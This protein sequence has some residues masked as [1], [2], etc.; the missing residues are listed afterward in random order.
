MKGLEMMAASIMQSM[1]VDPI[2]VKVAFE[3]TV[4]DIQKQ[5]LLLHTK[6]DQI[7]VTC[8]DAY[9]LCDKLDSRLIRVELEL[10]TLP[11]EDIFDNAKHNQL[12]LAS[13]TATTNG[14]INNGRIDSSNGNGKT[15]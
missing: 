15:N 9:A 5:I 2:Q 1:G 12:L 8:G 13:A 3:K 6:L 11:V 7:Q 14:V 4:A 10:K